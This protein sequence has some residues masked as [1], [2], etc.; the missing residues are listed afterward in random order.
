[1]MKERTGRE[2]R[3]AAAA[4]RQMHAWAL[5]QEIAERVVRVDPGHQLAARIGPY[6]TISR[7][8]GACGSRIAELAGEELGWEVL[9]KALLDH[10][11]H[12]CN[13]S[14]SLVELVD[15]TPSNWAHDILGPWIDRQV[16]PHEKY[17]RHMARIA[18]AA[19]RRGNVIFV[20]RGVQF[21]LP[22][23]SGLAVRI[24]APEKYR[25]AQLVERHGFTD[26]EAR[27]YLKEADEGRREFVLRYFHRDIHDPHLYDLVVN[28][29]AL[30]PAGA[31][32]LIVA[33]VKKRGALRGAQSAGSGA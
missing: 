15:E 11:A 2:P 32:A 10:V 5:A 27:R 19:A 24:V 12:R 23:G 18:L 1:M 26:A 8:A 33:A 31:A 16:V 4:E 3:I 9:D 28:A 21:L 30:G 29:E 20:G 13:V 22:R 17:I 6:V 7:E 14:R 25:V